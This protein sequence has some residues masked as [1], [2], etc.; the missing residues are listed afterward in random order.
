MPPDT[1]AAEAEK[2]I[3]QLDQMAATIPLD[4]PWTAP[5]AVEWDSQTFETWK[6]NNVASDGGRFLLDVAITS[7]FSAEPRDLS[8]L[9]VLFYIA[10][11]GNESNPGTI[12]RL[13]STGGG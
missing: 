13:V 3:V 9:F 6:Q 2:A 7:I 11:A 8:L 4:A 5:N 1:G 12:E 10:A